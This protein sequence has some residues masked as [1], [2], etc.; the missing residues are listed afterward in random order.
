VQDAPKSRPGIETL[1]GLRRHLEAAVLGQDEAIAGLSDALLAGEMGHTPAGRPRSMVLI[2]GPTGT[3]KTSAVTAASAHLYGTDAVAR[4]NAAEF[5]S[6]ER[7]P[8]LL[9]TGPGQ[10]GLL[11]AELARLRRAGGRILLL[12]EIEKAHPRVSD[13]L[14]GIEEA[15]VTLASGERLDLSDLHVVATSNVGSSGVVDMEGVARSSL[16]RYVLQEASAHFRPEV[17]AR[18]TAILVFAQLTRDTQVRICRQML[19]AEAAFQSGVL[20]RRFGHPHLVRAGADVCARLVSEGWSR[21]LGARP[22]RNAVERRVRGALVEAQLRG[23]LGPGVPETVLVADAR[24][25][26]RAAVGRAAFVL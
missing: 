20:S 11:G 10:G 4:I 25:G 15:A 16:R 23:A 3:G 2:L 19:E 14:L 9:G 17:V 6:E 5:A 22:M 1:R 8:L 18:F 21:R 13:L 26:V 7:V 24:A 12:D